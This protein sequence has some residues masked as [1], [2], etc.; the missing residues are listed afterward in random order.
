MHTSTTSSPF[1]CL[2]SL[3]VG[4]VS[5]T[6]GFWVQRQIDNRTITLRKGYQM[7]EKFGNLENLRLAA[8]LTHGGKFQ[9]Y[10]FADTDIYKWLEAVSYDLVNHPDPDLDRL[11][12]E[13]IALMAKAQMPDGYLNT[14][15]Q[16]DSPS[17]PT[18]P[19]SGFAHTKERWSGLDHSHE[20]YTAGH[21]MQ[22]AVAHHRATGK[23]GLLDIARRLADNMVATFGPGKNEAT[24][25]HPEVEMGLVEMYRETG[26]RRYLELAGYLVDQRGQNKMRGF[27]LWGPAYHQDRVPVRQATE[28][29][30]HAVRQLYLT[31]GVTDIFLETGEP[32]LMDS[33]QRLWS[34]LA[35][36]KTY[37]TGG[38]GSRHEGEA[39]G[40]AY[41]LPADRCY[42][43]TCAAIAGMMWNWRMLQATGEARFADAMERTLYNNFLS[44]LS[45]DGEHY[46]YVNPLH[47]RGGI[48]RV[49]WFDVA[50]C[51][52]NIMRQ[53]AA[54][55]YYIATTS[56]T[57]VQLHHFISA[58][59]K[60]RSGVTLQLRT[61]YPRDGKVTVTV[62][63]TDGSP[64]KLAVRVPAWAGGA[65]LKINGKEAGVPA[66]PGKYAE[67]ERTWRVGDQVEL[68]LP[69]APR[70][71]QANPRVDAVRNCLAIEYGPLVYCLEQ[72]D[73]PPQVNL[74]DVRIDPMG[75]LKAAW[76]EKVLGGVTTI[77]G[78][79]KVVDMQAW[80]DGLYRT[81]T[82]GD[83]PTT[84]IRFLAVPYYVWANRGPGAMRVWIPLD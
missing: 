15:R 20:M 5:L 67:I 36:H 58:S 61:K 84:P 12:D 34:D 44:G 42:C 68:D 3:P 10:E 69:M 82:A 29:E 24:D 23:P 38:F 70:L 11:A 46:F 28:I 41:E 47:S 8:G 59:M 78:E 27:G 19:F 63:A 80:G 74:E 2:R 51:P 64:W 73:L 75:P 17:V 7:L 25:G 54:I 45:L 57:G 50:C 55:G 81:V 16:L 22:A 35:A 83:L 9:G 6:D 43:E 39:F 21:L 37:L 33:L 48:Q 31:A 4:S 13:T 14:Y 71:I 60:V 77:Q 79:G 72:A 49:D 66:E 76:Q 32:A 65:G 62:E 18:S 30:G 53:T 1:A 56:Q 52:P 40:S 26:D